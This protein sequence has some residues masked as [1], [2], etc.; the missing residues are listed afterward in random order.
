VTGKD[1]KSI[2]PRGVAQLCS[3]QKQLIRPEWYLLGKSSRCDEVEGALI[4][5]KRVIGVFG[6]QRATQ[7]NDG[8]RRSEIRCL[9]R[10]LLDLEVR[11]TE[12]K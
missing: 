8:V 5:V 12:K 1:D 3:T 4:C 11:F 7:S 9:R 10:R 6:A 2:G